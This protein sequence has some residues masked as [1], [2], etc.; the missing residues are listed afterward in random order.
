MDGRRW[1]AQ[2]G[3]AHLALRRPTWPRRQA[4]S[5]AARGA[6]G[7]ASRVTG[8]ESDFRIPGPK[9]TPWKT[10]LTET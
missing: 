9:K 8:L 2:A 10:H 1:L 6:D 3:A 5:L 4:A 7:D